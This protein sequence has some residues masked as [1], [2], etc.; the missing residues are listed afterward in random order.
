ML[1]DRHTCLD[2]RKCF[3]VGGAQGQFDDLNLICLSHAQEG[4]GE[5]VCEICFFQ[6]IML[7][8]CQ[9]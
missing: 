8:C 5:W 4:D 1:S 2:T 6:P 3:T 9:I 7:E